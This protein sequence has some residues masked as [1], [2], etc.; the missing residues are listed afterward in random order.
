MPPHKTI[1]P[2]VHSGS[3]AWTVIAEGDD[4]EIWTFID[5]S[6]ARDLLTMHALRWALNEAIARGLDAVREY[7]FQSGS[8]L[9]HY[10]L[11][12]DLDAKFIGAGPDAL[13]AVLEA[14]AYLEPKEAVHGN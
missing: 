14:T 5:E 12:G 3:V 8:G 13:T 2:L 10:L 11:Q 6:D 9:V 7:R 1:K 4:P